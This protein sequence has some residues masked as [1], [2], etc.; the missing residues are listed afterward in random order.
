MD[1]NLRRACLCVIGLML[2]HL[3]LD[4]QILPAFGSSRSGT[5]GMQFLKLGPDA[6]SNAMA[7]SVLGNITD[8]AAVFWNPAGLAGLDTQKVHAQLGR[9]DYF[10]GIG[11]NHGCVAFKPSK[12][13]TF[14]FGIMSYSTGDMPV[15]TEFM[16]QGTGQNFS[17]SDL[18]LSFSYAQVLTDQFRFGVSLKY[19]N[20]NI[21]GVTTHNGLFDF[22]FQYNIG[23]KGIRFGVAISNFGFNVKPSGEVI[24]TTLSAEKQIDQF[25]EVAVPAIF[26]VGTAMYLLK[27]ERHV[28]DWTLQLDHPTDN[29]EA[30]SSGLEYAFKNTL[31]LRTGYRFGVDGLRPSFGAGVQLK[32]RFGHMRFDYSYRSMQ[33]LGN[34]NQL[35]LTLGIL[36]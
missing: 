25:D 10:A 19:A 2:G 29:K 17:V 21:A 23:I 5:T 8:P 16:P 34:I 24:I 28:V 11:M 33:A 3:A 18:M 35:S 7:G 30:V 31:F 13:R 32:R 36:P 27:S 22:G 9:T 4:A 1:R 20:E 15:T 26:R 14:G 6:R 12:Y